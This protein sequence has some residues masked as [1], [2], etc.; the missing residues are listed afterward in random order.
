[1]KDND[2]DDDDIKEEDED[3]DGSSHSSDDDSSDEQK[4]SKPKGVSGLIEIEN[5]NRNPSRAP[6]TGMCV[7]FFCF[8]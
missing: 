1:M 3:T 2:D 8:F 4:I 5:P 7:V 6:T